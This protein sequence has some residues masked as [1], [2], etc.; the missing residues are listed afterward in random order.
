[1]KENKEILI[2]KYL[3]EN[4]SAEEKQELENWLKENLTHQ[5]EF[6]RLKKIWKISLSTKKKNENE[7]SVEEAWT[8]FK[9]LAE[10]QQESTV[11]KQKLPFLKIAAVIA[12][13]VTTFIVVKS[14]IPKTNGLIRETLPQKAIVMITVSA[15]DSAKEFF[16]PD[17]S[18]IYLYKHSKFTYPKEFDKLERI[19]FLTGEA[20]FEVRHQNPPFVAFCQNTRT[21]VLGTSFNIKGYEKEKDVEVIVV[22]GRVEFSDGKNLMGEK[23][24]LIPNEK[25][26]YNRESISISKTVNTRKNFK[27]REKNTFIK[28]VKKFIKKLKK[29]KK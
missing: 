16:L 14:F 4:I 1:M 3:S 5:E 17:S 11:K 20:F 18:R 13:F 2:S 6:N 15:G 26:L 19:T 23:I 24:V 12:F 22:T 25:V 7:A 8:Q 28:R 10:L 29:K 9:L 21:K 27:K